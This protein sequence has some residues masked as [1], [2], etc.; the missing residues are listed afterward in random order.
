MRHG[1]AFIAALLISPGEEAR[2]SEIEPIDPLESIMPKLEI[3]RRTDERQN[4]FVTMIPKSIEKDG[5]SA[6]PRN[7]FLAGQ[8]AKAAPESDW[9]RQRILTMERPR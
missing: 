4:G 8:I 3:Q 6:E 9:N 5:L 1:C 7:N 2:S